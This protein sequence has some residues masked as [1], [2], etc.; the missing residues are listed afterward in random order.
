MPPRRGAALPMHP[1]FVAPR[2]PRVHTS[3]PGAKLE[4]RWRCGAEE[5]EAAA[6]SCPAKTAFYLMR[7]GFGG[8]RLMSGDG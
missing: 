2:P 6:A 7:S 3:R 8:R 4:E 5:D 1:L